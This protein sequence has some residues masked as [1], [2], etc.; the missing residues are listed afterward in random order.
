MYLVLLRRRQ[1]MDEPRSMM[2]IIASLLKVEVFEFQACLMEA[3]IAAAV[4]DAIAVPRLG[5][6]EKAFDIDDPHMAAPLIV[7]MANF[8]QYALKAVHH[9]RSVEA[10]IC[11]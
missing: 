9:A 6:E 3:L 4:R 1:V 8:H 10:L 5:I 2:L 7:W 11:A